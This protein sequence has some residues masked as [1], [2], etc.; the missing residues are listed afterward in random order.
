MIEEY[1]VSNLNKKERVFTYVKGDPANETVVFMHGLGGTH[2]GYR[3][4]IDKLAEK[5]FVYAPHIPSFGY[6]T[7]PLKFDIE[8]YIDNLW[9]VFSTYKIKNK[10]TIIGHSFGGAIATKMLLRD[11]SMFE[12]LVLINS[13]GIS[14]KD[15]TEYLDWILKTMDVSRKFLRNIKTD[16][17]MIKRTFQDIILSTVRLKDIYKTAGIIISLNMLEDFARVEVPTSLLWSRQDNYFPLEV[18]ERIN[19]TITGSHLKIVDSKKGHS[20]CMVEPDLVLNNI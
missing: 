2:I 11:Q 12:K 16:K 14:P 15:D 19:K 8:N 17:K 5:Y 1:L 20:W 18:A 6:S 7:A 3:E 13:A 9:Q 10:A 4:L